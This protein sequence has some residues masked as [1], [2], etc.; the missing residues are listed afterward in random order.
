MYS[1]LKG[2]VQHWFRHWNIIDSRLAD[3]CCTPINYYFAKL[4]NIKPDNDALH[5][6]TIRQQIQFSGNWLIRC[7]KKIPE[8]LQCRVSFSKHQYLSVWI[9]DQNTLNCAMKSDPPLSFT[10]INFNFAGVVFDCFSINQQL[11]FTHLFRHFG[12]SLWGV[13]GYL[14]VLFENMNIFCDKL[15]CFC[16]RSLR[17]GL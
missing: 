2:H 14:P 17:S 15:A 12:S 9:V 13:R 5:R 16:L 3:V 11:A 6:Q 7:H 8:S 1:N 10:S 4:K